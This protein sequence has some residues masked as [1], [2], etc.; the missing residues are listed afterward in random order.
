MLTQLDCREMKPVSRTGVALK[1][2]LGYVVKRRPI[3]STATL[4]ERTITMRRAFHLTGLL[5]ALALLCAVPAAPA[6]DVYTI[7]PG[8]CSIVF[9]VAHTGL[10]YTYGMFR[11]AEGKYQID[12]NDPANC[13]F[14]L[15]IKANSL[16]TNNAKRDEH[17]RSP[18]FFN[19]QQYPDITFDSTRCALVESREKSAC[20]R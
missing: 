3:A 1:P 19:V 5:P 9:S 20:T 4:H 15:I 17:L 10:S 11:T 7:D 13:R 14:Q 18:D 8:H 6:A 2:S 12:T 16:D